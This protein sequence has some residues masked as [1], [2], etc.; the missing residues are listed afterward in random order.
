LRFSAPKAEGGDAGEN[1]EA[2]GDADAVTA[3]TLGQ[4]NLQRVMKM[5]PTLLPEDGKDDRGLMDLYGAVWTQ[6]FHE[7]V[8]VTSVIGGYLVQNKHNDQPGEV[9]TPVPRAQQQ[10]AMKF[11]TEQVLATPTWLLDPAVTQRL[12][13]SMA[14]GVQSLFQRVMLLVLLDPAR[15]R[16]LLAQ[17]AQLGPQ[18]YR[19]EHML[20]ELRRSVFQEL[21]TAG[22]ITAPRRSLQRHYVDTL[23]ARLGLRGPTVLDDGQALIRAEMRELKA[24]LS[25]KAT[26]GDITRRAHLLG[27][28][29]TLDKALDPRAASMASAG[30]TVVRANGLH[31]MGQGHVHDEQCW[32]GQGFLP[33]TKLLATTAAWANWATWTTWAD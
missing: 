23:A 26:G 6:W 32:Q 27:L 16:R 33:G 5:L 25:S 13:A 9:A 29:D 11:F 1:Q 7:S 3:T 20:L 4:R 12:G 21:G 8:H 18:A 24:L 30:S 10:R 17:E 22:A 15:S 19:M 31:G 14:P 28:V 2:V